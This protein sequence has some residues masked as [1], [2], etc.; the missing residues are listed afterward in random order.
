VINPKV[1]WDDLKVPDREKAILRQIADQ[2]RKRMDRGPGI[3]ALFAGESGT[4]K[5]MAAE[6]IA[7]E[8]NLLLYRIDLSGVVSKYIEETEKNL[9]TLFDAAEEGGAILL[10]DEADALFGKRSEVT[11]SHD[12]YASSAANYLLQRIEAGRGLTVLETTAKS[13]LDGEFVRR[14]SFV[15]D[16]PLP[17]MEDRL[18]IWRRLLP[19]KTLGGKLDYQY[20]AKFQFTGGGIHDLAVN[21]AH[22]AQ[23]GGTPVTM[24][25]AL[26]AVKTELKKLG[27][28]FDEGAELDPGELK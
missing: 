15:V 24:P 28:R 14:L 6:V 25:I 20:L 16:F 12:R 27:K 9:S 10:L 3:S 23:M 8:L 5:T 21:A 1:D 4:G 13:A 19:P 7:N 17:G 11:D 26:G 2:A 22:L 18:A